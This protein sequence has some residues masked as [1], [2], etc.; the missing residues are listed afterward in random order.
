MKTGARC[1]VTLMLG[2][3]LAL[4]IGAIARDMLHNCAVDPKVLPGNTSSSA[5]ITDAA[6]NTAG[7]SNLPP[8]PPEARGEPFPFAVKDLII[9]GGNEAMVYLS[10]GSH[11]MQ[12]RF[13]FPKEELPWVRIPIGQE[14]TNSVTWISGPD[15]QE[16]GMPYRRGGIPPP[17]N[18]HLKCTRKKAVSGWIICRNPPVRGASLSPYPSQRIGFEIALDRLEFD[19]GRQYGLPMMPVSNYFFPLP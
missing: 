5:V 3:L 9:S 6:G 15:A 13:D 8:D 7:E 18:P 17:P 2:G 1:R 4:G 16:Y 12:V 10:V 19:N 11:V 14:D